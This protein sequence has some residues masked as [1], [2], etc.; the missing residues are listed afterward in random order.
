LL[1]QGAKG[2]LDCWAVGCCEGHTNGAPQQRTINFLGTGYGVLLTTY[3]PV[4][5]IALRTIR[6]YGVLRRSAMNTADWVLLEKCRQDLEKDNS[7]VAQIA[8]YEYGGNTS[9]LL[10]RTIAEVS[11]PCNRL[12]GRR[13]TIRAT[14]LHCRLE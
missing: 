1:V 6:T 8:H 10:P 4:P 12:P 2:L 3:L 14:P 11:T 13:D 5:V 9:I 7:T